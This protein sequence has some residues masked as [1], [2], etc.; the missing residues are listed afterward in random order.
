MCAGGRFVYDF[1][2]DKLHRLSEGH[3]WITAFSRIIKELLGK[4]TKKRGGTGG[5]D[6]EADDAI[7]EAAAAAGV[8]SGPALSESEDEQAA[9]SDGEVSEDK[10]TFVAYRHEH[11][12][13]AQVGLYSH[14]T[15]R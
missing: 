9:E 6:T 11:G 8:G 2:K 12:D 7:A 13:R 15:L 4:K 3:N 14:S 10:T 5:G 1:Q